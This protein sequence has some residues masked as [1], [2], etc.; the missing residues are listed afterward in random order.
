[1]DELKSNEEDKQDAQ[2]DKI[3]AENDELKSDEE[4]ICDNENKTIP[5]EIELN[6]VEEKKVDEVKAENLDNNEKK[7]DEIKL[8]LSVLSTT[9]QEIANSATKTANEIKEVHKLYH[10]EYAKRLSSMQDKLD[11][12]NEIEKRRYFD[13]ILT[14]IA[15]LYS[16]NVAAIEEIADEKLKK[17]FFYMFDEM[18]SILGNNGVYKQESNIG[19]KR[20]TKHCQVEG[21]IHTDDPNLHDTIAKSNNIGFYIE[22]RTLIKE[23]VDV[24]INK[25][26]VKNT[27]SESV[28]K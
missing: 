22:N 10:N 14:E 27:D 21:R 17:R 11:V 3:N 23:R 19:D 20:N 9:V 2:P 13:D 25:L 12:Y 1:M 26:E 15:R 24:Y 5:D 16:N 6:A 4:L 8:D 18:L 28:N 7:L